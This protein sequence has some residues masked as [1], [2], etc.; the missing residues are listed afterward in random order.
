MEGLGEGAEFG[1]EEA[2]LRVDELEVFEEVFEGVFL[3]VADCGGAEDPG[4]GVAVHDV[5]EKRDC[6]VAQTV[7]GGDRFEV[8][9]VVAV[10]HARLL[11]EVVDLA[12]ED[13]EEGAE[14]GEFATVDFQLGGEAHTFQPS[15]AAEEVEE[16]RFGVVIAVVGEEEIG[17]FAAL[18]A[19]AEELVAG[20]TGGGFEGIA[21]LLGEAGDV[22]AADLEGEVVLFGEIADESGIIAGEEAA[23]LVVEVAEGEFAA[24]GSEE[25]VE[26]CHGVASPGDAEEVGLPEFEAWVE[27]EHGGSV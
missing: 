3:F 2:A 23:G 9:G 26:E 5:L 7:S 4:D 8:G 15:G 1:E 24:T 21:L 18:G 12:A 16:D 22:H 10:E 19:F 6:F 27:G 25:G 14:D 17:T 11:R 13:L 20:L